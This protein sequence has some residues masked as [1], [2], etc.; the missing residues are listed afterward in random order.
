MKQNN[1]M[2][3]HQDA[4]L[5]SDK[6]NSLR[7]NYKKQLFTN[8]ILSV[9][10]GSDIIILMAFIDRNPGI[11]KKLVIVG[12]ILAIASIKSAMS[13]IKNF[14]ELQKALKQQEQF[15]RMLHNLDLINNETISKGKER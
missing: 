14:G 7:N 15:N 1:N 6:V 5:I 2:N 12:G 4:G 3:K 11:V 9:L 13:F 8:N 10:L